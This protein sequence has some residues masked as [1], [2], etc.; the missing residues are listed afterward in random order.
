MSTNNSIMDNIDSFAIIVV[1]MGIFLNLLP[2]SGPS[3]MPDSKM[4]SCDL[5]R[6]FLDKSFNAVQTLT[7]LFSL[8]DHI[9]FDMIFLPRECDY[10]GTVIASIFEQFDSHS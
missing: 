2:A 10:S 9:D 7:S 5:M 6:G 4:R 1:R 3:S 8:F